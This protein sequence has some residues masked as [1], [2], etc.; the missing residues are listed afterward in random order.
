LSHPEG[1]DFLLQARVCVFFGLFRIGPK[2]VTFCTNEIVNKTLQT[3]SALSAFSPT[4][5]VNFL[6]SCQV[7]KMS[8]VDDFLNDLEGDSFLMCLP[9][10]AEDASPSQS[11]ANAV[12]PV[13]AVKSK[14]M[15]TGT[16]LKSYVLVLIS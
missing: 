16:L 1:Q 9:D 14:P 10:D 13:K 4:V 11:E 2:L 15:K 7:K 8:Q 5:I 12:K 3:F 6:T